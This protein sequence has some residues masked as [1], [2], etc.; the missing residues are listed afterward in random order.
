MRKIITAIL[1]VAM[2]IAI[3]VNPTYAESSSEE[4]SVQTIPNQMVNYDNIYKKLHIYLNEENSEQYHTIDSNSELDLALSILHNDTEQTCSKDLAKNSVI[5]TVEF[6]SGFG[7]TIEFQAFQA[8]RKQIKTNGELRDFRN[9]LNNFAKQYHTQ[10]MS[11]YLSLL[12]S[13]EYYDIDVVE[14]SP[15]AIMKIENEAIQKSDLINLVIYDNVLN[16]YVEST[17]TNV[18][19]TTED[20]FGASSLETDSQDTIEYS[21]WNEMLQHIGAKDIVTSETYTGEGI[22]IGVLEAVGNKIYDENNENFAGKDITIQTPSDEVHSHA[23]EVLSV[24]TLIAPE[25][26]YYFSSFLYTHDIAN[27]LESLVGVNC[28][29]INMSFGSAANGYVSSDGIV[30]YYSHY[31]YITIV[32]SAG[33]EKNENINITSPGYGFNTITVGGVVQTNTNKLIHDPTACYDSVYPI[34]K[35]NLSAINR[36]VIPN[37]NPSGTSGTS[38]AAPQVTA[39]IALMAEYMAKERDYQITLFPESIMAILTSTASKTDDYSFDNEY[40]DE[41]IGAGLINLERMISSE[42]VVYDHTFEDTTDGMVYTPIAISL[43]AGQ[44]L[45]LSLVMFSHV[46]SDG[47]VNSVL[48]TDYDIFIYPFMGSTV[49]AS[50]TF[51]IDSNVELIRYTATTTGVVRISIIAYEDCVHADGLDDIAW[52][53]SIID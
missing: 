49:L 52:S 38:I 3:I 23:T 51:S 17:N 53:Y 31:L 6:Y 45:Q 46:E 15:Y 48:F 43:E 42:T 16:I 32:K 21:T 1:T 37:D 47:D 28:D 13:F 11:E 27:R 12:S 26:K 24:A 33:N 41:K 5:I 39:C 40:F 50:S 8:E 4:T 34:N 44:E 29:I 22:T 30:D 20:E 2:L 25:A 35:P 9:R 36:I 7:N 14:Y 18:E 10:I 19:Y